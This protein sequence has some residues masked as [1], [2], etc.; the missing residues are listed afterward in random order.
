MRKAKIFAAMLMA[1]SSLGAFAQHQFCRFVLRDSFQ[2]S[3]ALIEGRGFVGNAH[4]CYGRHF[5]KASRP[6]D[7]GKTYFALP[8]IYAPKV[9]VGRHKVWV[10]GY[11]FFKLLLGF[12]KLAY[13]RQAY[14]IVEK[15]GVQQGVPLI[16]RNPCRITCFNRGSLPALLECFHGA[17]QV[18]NAQIAHH[19]GNK[20]R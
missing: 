16:L 20:G 9:Y 4:A 14:R 6:L 15:H 5:C 13:V 19:G 11:C 2:S 7:N 18:R 8:F 12:F 1:M 17:D 3:G 10:Y